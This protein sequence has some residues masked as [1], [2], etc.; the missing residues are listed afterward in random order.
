M[1]RTTGSDYG[2]R[3]VN[4]T[5]RSRDS[6]RRPYL[7]QRD[8]LS[9]LADGSVPRPEQLETHT[10]GREADLVLSKGLCGPGILKGSAHALKVGSA[11]SAP[12]PR[13][14]GNWARVPSFAFH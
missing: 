6:R 13:K 1:V 8:R 14:V 10:D 3:T 11:R 4:R 2:Q 7:P 12:L 9:A 5:D